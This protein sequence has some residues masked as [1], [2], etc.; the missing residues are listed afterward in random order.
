M[1]D[2]IKGSIY[3]ALM[4]TKENWRVLFLQQNPSQ[5]TIDSDQIRLLISLYH[6][7]KS[8]YMNRSWSNWAVWKN[9]SVM[10]VIPWCKT[11]R[12]RACCRDSWGNCPWKWLILLSAHN[13]SALTAAQSWSTFAWV[14]EVAI[15]S[16]KM[17]HNIHLR[18]EIYCSVIHS[19]M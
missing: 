12:R 2:S 18:E 13:E 4:L 9:V 19:C 16:H 14:H 7:Y 5:L 11:W 10:M 17:K 1:I 6:S 3:S 15:C 8:L